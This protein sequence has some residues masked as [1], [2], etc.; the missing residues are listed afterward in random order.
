MK[1]HFIRAIKLTLVTVI[2]FGV[3]YPLFITGIAKI[4][5]PNEGRGQE[6]IVGDKVVGFELIGQKFDDD[7]YFNSRPSFVN[8]NAASAGGSNKGSTSPEYLSMV[9]AR[10]DTF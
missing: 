5:G 10:I 3:L 7:R 8:Y 4:V 2:F 1:T 9:Q 6:I